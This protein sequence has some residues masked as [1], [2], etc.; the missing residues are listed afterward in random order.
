MNGGGDVHFY[1]GSFT[2]RRDYKLVPSQKN[3]G[4]RALCIPNPGEKYRERML[5]VPPTYCRYLGLDFRKRGHPSQ[6]I[7]KIRVILEKKK[8]RD[9]INYLCTC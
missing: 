2:R 8:N 4:Q 7:R 5:R 1:R 9:Y 6:Y 3:A